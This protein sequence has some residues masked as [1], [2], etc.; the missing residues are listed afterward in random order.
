MQASNFFA[1]GLSLID[2]YVRLV[3]MLWPCIRIEDFWDDCSKIAPAPLWFRSRRSH[4]LSS[5]RYWST[6][7]R[8]TAL[9][10]KPVLHA[11]YFTA[12]LLSGSSNVHGL[13]MWKENADSRLYIKRVQALA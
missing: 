4:C 3:Y 10:V 13:L 12:R 2:S 7:D 5:V 11:T 9:A 8:V 1:S 6:M